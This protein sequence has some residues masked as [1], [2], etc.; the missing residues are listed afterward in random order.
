MARSARGLQWTAVAAALIAAGV[1]T[2]F[3]A[4]VGWRFVLLFALGAAL[5][6]VLYLTAFSFT[7][8]YRALFTRGEISGVR[9]QLIMLALAMLL[10]APLLA[11]PSV[12]GIQ[13]AGAVAALGLQVAIGAFAFG[14]GM[15][16][17]GGCGSGTLYSAGG[18]SLRMGVVLVAFC[19]GSFW[20]SLHMGWWQTLPSWRGIALAQVFGSPTAIVMQLTVVAMLWIGLSRVDRKQEVS[21]RSGFMHLLEQHRP[22]LVGAVLLGILNALVLVVAGHPWTIT[23]AFALW[24][25]KAATVLGW[26]PASAPFWQGAFQSAALSAPVLHDTTSITNAGIVLGALAAAGATAQL[27]FSTRV[28]AR[29]LAAAVLGGLMMGYGARIAYGCNIGAFFSGV[30]STSLHG[31]LWIAAGLCGNWAGVQL[32]LRFHREP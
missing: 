26:D 24:G 29:A 14:I 10:F 7:G 19:A 25:A 9:A 32:R 17:A 13:L 22:L 6:L 2:V 12:F 8:A 31:W 27:T 16:L 23:W 21:P 4:H 28:S 15:Q 18:G 1:V 30:A 3:L 5:G 11:Q 20:A